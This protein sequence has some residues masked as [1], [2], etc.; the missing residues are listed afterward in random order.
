MA[1]LFSSLAGVR[2]Q[3]AITSWVANAQPKSFHD[4]QYR[5]AAVLCHEA[6]VSTINYLEGR[7][8][9]T[10]V[11]TEWEHGLADLWAQAS[12]AVAPFKP[13]L[14]RALVWA[15][16]GGGTELWTHLS[17]EK[18]DSARAQLIYKLRDVSPDDTGFSGVLTA[19]A[20]IKA[21]NPVL[22]VALT[23]GGVFGLAC[24]YSGLQL[25]GMGDTVF[26]FF[27]LQFSTKHAGV[28]AIALGAATIILTFR[29]VLKTVVELG[30]I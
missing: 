19:P 5:H 24:I 20:H 28:A 7:R 16:L 4:D 26:T 12:R 18:L 22:L 13:G 10:L 17:V 11:D 27:E 25:M 14:A 30:R 8:D 9:G 29:K 3:H 6:L 15:E 21:G 23:L 2:F 1:K